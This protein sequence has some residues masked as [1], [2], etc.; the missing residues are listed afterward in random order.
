MSQNTCWCTQLL[1]VSTVAADAQGIS[2]KNESI[3]IAT[4]QL[5]TNY[6][7]EVY[8]EDFQIYSEDKM[9]QS[10]KE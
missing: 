6:H 9:T 8:T 4:D 10:F 5:N 7:L 2:Y 3:Y 1:L